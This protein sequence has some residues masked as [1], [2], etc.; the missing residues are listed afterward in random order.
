MDPDILSEPPD[1]KYKSPDGVDCFPAGLTTC[2]VD[3]A[4]RR[5]ARP[6]WRADP[7]TNPMGDIYLGWVMGGEVARETPGGIMKSCRICCVSLVSNKFNR[8]CSAS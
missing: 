5:I 2:T 3:D 4:C 7:S 6:A 1:F 8:R